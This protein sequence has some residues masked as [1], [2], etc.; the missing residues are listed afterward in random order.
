MAAMTLSNDIIFCHSGSL[1][2]GF[3]VA[4][5]SGNT[6]DWGWMF[7][8]EF[9]APTVLLYVWLYF[10]LEYTILPLS[11]VTFIY[12]HMAFLQL[13]KER[14]K[15][16]R[17][18]R[19]R[20]RRERE[21]EEIEREWDITVSIAYFSVMWFDHVETITLKVKAPVK[22]LYLLLLWVLSTTCQY[23]YL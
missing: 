8:S 18:E 17:T 1:F 4:Q 11:F 9:F 23:I 16:E 7:K 14:E 15:R 13:A 22:A 20:D 21:W 6:D 5:P 19:Y 12:Y 10:G 2:V 3:D